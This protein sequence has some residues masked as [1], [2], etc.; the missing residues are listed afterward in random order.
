[1][2]TCKIDGLVGLG[3]GLGLEKDG[4]WFRWQVTCLRIVPG[5]LLLFASIRHDSD[6]V[7]EA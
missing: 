4:A 5:L 7:F 2:R 1:M 6:G 3:L